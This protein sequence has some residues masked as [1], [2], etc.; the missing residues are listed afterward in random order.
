MS[1]MVVPTRTGEILSVDEMKK[2]GMELE[3]VGISGV[4]DVGPSWCSILLEVNAILATGTPQRI[5]QWS[6]SQTYYQRDMFA[7]IHFSLLMLLRLQLFRIPGLTA[8]NTPGHW[9][10]CAR[11]SREDIAIAIAA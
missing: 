6:E 10:T 9:R 5:V 8:M 2:M 11:T 1:Q 7:F 3:I 4:P